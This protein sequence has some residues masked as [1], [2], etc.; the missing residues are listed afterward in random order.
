MTR[1]LSERELYAAP[2]AR[3]AARRRAHLVACPSC[4][5][6]LDR[7]MAL[8]AAVRDASAPS[9]PDWERMEARILRSIRAAEAPRPVVRWSLAPA[10]LALA[11]AVL[12]VF[13]ILVGKRPSAEGTKPALAARTETVAP[14]ATLARVP[15]DGAVSEK[16]GVGAPPRGVRLLEDD[17]TNSGAGGVARIAVDDN[18]AIDEFGPTALTIASL[19]E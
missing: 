15:L 17:K 3:L 18:I 16:F 9:P 1:C 14:M 4:T 7:M 10:A 2:E 5:T 6:R 8:R 12:V 13:A 11:A 19:D